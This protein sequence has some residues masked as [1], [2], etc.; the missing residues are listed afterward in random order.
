MIAERG[1]GVSTEQIAQEAGVARTQ[2]YKHFTDAAD[3][4]GAIVDQAL[5]LIHTE[6]APL[7]NLH[8]TPLEMITS[9][10]DG[11]TRWLADN[12]HLYRYL[13]MHALSAG[14]G[15]HAIRDVK[16]TIGT[17]LTRLFEHYLALFRMD[18]RVAGSVAFGVVGLVDSCTAHWL[19]DPRRLDHSEFVAL[20]ARWVWRI[21]DD[22]LRSG[23]V[24]L[25][26]DAPLAAPDLKFPPAPE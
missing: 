26:A 8:G 19:D 15:P 25:D 18:T 11:H 24:E 13:G 5:Q 16:T 2:L 10:V 17:H 9:A 1:P 22:T 21:L 20:L 4:H 14:D 3:V 6:L 7:W 12:R 23:G